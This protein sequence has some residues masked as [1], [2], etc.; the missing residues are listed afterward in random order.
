MH[1]VDIYH[2]LC[3][4]GFPTHRLKPPYN[5]MEIIDK[6]DRTTFTKLITSLSKVVKKGGSTDKLPLQSTTIYY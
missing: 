3:Q 1:S 2:T 6:I 4:V 5:M